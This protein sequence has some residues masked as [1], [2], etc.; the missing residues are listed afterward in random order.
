MA[1]KLSGA[2]GGRYAVRQ[3]ADINVTPFVDILLVLL[4]IFMVA[5]PLATVDLPVDLPASTASPRPAADAPIYLGMASDGALQLDQQRVDPQTLQMQLDRRSGGDRE[6]RIFV[7]ADRRIAY[8]EL[9]GVMD[10]L[11]DAG[12]LKVALVAQEQPVQ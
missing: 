2:G 4:I 11:R 9:M 5:A 1:L 3:N 7:R 12:Y 6:R 10:L 8:G